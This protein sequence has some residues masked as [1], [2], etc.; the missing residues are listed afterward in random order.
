MKPITIRDLMDI[1]FVSGPVLSPDGKRAAY[2]VKRQDYKKNRYDACI[3]LL[4][5]ESGVSRQL[6]YDG[7][8]S[9]PVWED[10]HTL[11]FSTQRGADDKPEKHRKKTVFYRLDVD[12][13]EARRAFELSMDVGDVR[14]LGD[15][16][17]VVLAEVDLNAPPEDLDGTLRED[18]EDYHVIEEVPLWANGRGFVSRLRASLFLFDPGD[19][20]QKK[21]TNDFFNVETFDVRDGKILYAGCEYR[22]VIS[23]FSEVRLYDL[24]TG[25][26]CV[27]VAPGVYRVGEA[28]LTD[29]GAV[30][31][32]S[33]LEPWGRGQN[34][35]WYR[36]D[37]ATGKLTM[38][39]AMDRCIGCAGVTDIAGG[40]GKSAVTA[41]GCVWFIAQRGYR[42]EVC[43]L[44]AD[45][46]VETVAPFEG[47][48]LWL[49][50][51]GERVL[52]TACAPNG[53]TELY[54][55]RE[56]EIAK[57]T[58]HND[59]FLNSHDVAQVEYIP[60]ANA[61]GLSIDGWVLKPT[62]FDPEKKYPGV[63]E[64][65]GG[66]RG[67]YGTPLVHEMQALC[68]AGY[69][70][71]FC[72][73]RGSEGYGEAFADLR[74]KYGDIDYKDLMA[75]TDHVLAAVPQL[76]ATRLAACGGSYG[77][78]MCNWIEGHTD[79]FAALASQ[80]SISNWVSDYGSSEIGVTF[81]V[82]ELGGDPWSSHEA[83]WDQ[84]PL[85]YADR[86]KTPILFIHALQDYNCTV[87]Q[88]VEMFTAMKR[89]G[90]PA[91]MV[92]FEG[93]NHSLSRSGKPRHR[94]RRLE[95][96]FNWFGKYLKPSPDN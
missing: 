53:L 67:A 56:G 37:T 40:S 90:V 16:R 12:G 46:T 18:W 7:K 75:F 22:D 34:H 17:Y 51:D 52:F 14:P 24:G 41:K 72:N 81:D 47:T 49:D 27:L 6:T 85:K 30:L 96:I 84:S 32:M 73:P 63:L 74:G 77:G 8:T 15:G 31:S 43:R 20:A 23:S 66:P 92:L 48:A 71:F 78:F 35:D 88:G 2:V 70:V 26:D 45:D 64:I 89:F 87:D 95:E 68:G 60:F 11:L 83:M 25:E 33:T 80:R 42:A 62:D 1:A 91:R 65:H 38:A 36:C 39:A 76:D 21:L 59:P 86:A 69:V 28:L 3:H 57:R 10:G 58:E 19:G 5:C 82:N 55:A 4:D 61:E 44:N 54:T 13:G 79:R 9:D 93:E 50:T 29:G 94:I